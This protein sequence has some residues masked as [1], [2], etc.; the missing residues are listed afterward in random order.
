[1]GS[2]GRGTCR[3]PVFFVSPRPSLSLV[4]GGAAPPIA[5][6]GREVA[7]GA[8]AVRGARTGV[9]SRS[10]IHRGLQPLAVR[11]RACRET[12]GG[13][14]VLA[15]AAAASTAAA[16]GR[17]RERRRRELRRRRRRRLRSV[18]AAAAAAAASTAA[19]VGRRRERRRRELRR[20]RRGPHA[21][22]ATATVQLEPVERAALPARKTKTEEVRSRRIIIPPP[23]RKPAMGSERF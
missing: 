9:S 17:R 12:R 4:G 3:G 8:L 19:A 22:R 6:R 16:V 5:R 13:A 1:M 11:V 21:V 10:R 7:T 15:A 23:A 18:R 20:R 2:R 14:A